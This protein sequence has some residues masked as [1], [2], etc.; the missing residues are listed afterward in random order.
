[1]LLVILCLF[2]IRNKEVNNI[3]K[4]FKLLL[5]L[6]CVVTVLYTTL[7][8]T[9]AM[10]F[11]TEEAYNAVYV[12]DSY[13]SLGSGFALGK[14]CIVTNEHVVTNS[15]KINLISYSGKQYKA[16]V[17]GLNKELDI[18]VLYVPNATF[19]HFTVGNQ[20]KIKDGDD[21]YA[22]GVP[23]SMS[24]TLTKGII[25]AKERNLGRYPYIQIDAAINEGNSGSPLLNEYGEVIGMI[26]F[27]IANSEG[28]S[29]A[30][31]IK[32]V[33]EYLTQLNIELDHVGN[34]VGNIEKSDNIINE[35]I[36][37]TPNKEE[38]N[39]N[40]DSYFSN[41]TVVALVIAGISLI[42]NIVLLVLLIYQKKKN[43]V[44]TYNQKERTDFEIEILG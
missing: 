40:V 22:I 43:L 8:S 24:Y 3:A 12:I 27:K 2:L 1:M 5:Y 21:V 34:V 14:N 32:R 29:L 28:I 10:G 7:L 13:N 20:S 23:K 35:V 41:I 11:S 39:D 4:P 6:L 31:P 17:M 38:H 26:T 44:L 18:A 36:I 19:P 9:V 15:D 42:G 33:C 25:S 16:V 30:I 37:P